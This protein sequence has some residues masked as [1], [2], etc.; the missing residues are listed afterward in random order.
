[1]NFRTTCGNNSDNLHVTSQTRINFLFI[2]SSLI[3]MIEQRVRAGEEK[4]T[5]EGSGERMKS[6]T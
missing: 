3:E 6:T 1:M 5:Q 2:F 4:W